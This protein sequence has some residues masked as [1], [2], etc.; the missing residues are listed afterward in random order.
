[1]FGT[2][3]QL[4]ELGMCYNPPMH[5]YCTP[6]RLSGPLVTTAIQLMWKELSYVKVGQCVGHATAR[7]TMREC[8]IGT[9]LASRPLA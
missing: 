2:E 5:Y 7:F 1:M 6:S 8:L 3:L 4:R 9:E